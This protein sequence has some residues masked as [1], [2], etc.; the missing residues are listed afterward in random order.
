M[1]KKYINVIH[2]E[3]GEFLQEFSDLPAFLDALQSEILS[4][5]ADLEYWQCIIEVIEMEEAE[6]NALPEWTGG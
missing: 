6:F 2:S 4:P 5:D 1:K 3:M